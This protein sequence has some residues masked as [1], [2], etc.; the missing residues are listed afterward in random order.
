MNR[1]DEYPD[2]QDDDQPPVDLGVRRRA[3]PRGTKLLLSIGVVSGVGALLFFTWVG[4]QNAAHKNP[5]PTLAQVVEAPPKLK[6]DI[7]P[8]PPAP[9]EPPAGVAPPSHLD[10]SLWQL[11]AMEEPKIDLVKKRRLESTM[12]GAQQSSEP[13]TPASNQAPPPRVPVMSSAGP[14][15]QLQALTLQPATASQL[16][17]RNLLLTQG[18]MIDCVLLTRLVSTQP[19]MI[20]CQA[21]RDILSNN[22]KVVLVDA[23]SKF[24]GYQ[25]AG[26]AQGQARVFVVW[27]RLITPAGVTINLDS[28]GTGPLGEGGL[29]GAVDYHFGDR[30]SGAILVSLIG[31]L[32]RWASNRGNSGGDGV[33]FD[34]TTD[35]AANAVTTVL[36]NS[37]NIPPTLYKNQGERVG[38]FVARDLDFSSVYDLKPAAR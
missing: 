33:R 26:I 23:G 1:H 17:D 22:G 6:L 32:G 11:P 21:T 4:S 10:P 5:V 35:G 38:I 7:P 9:A 27:S 37:I 25:Q 15:S 31:D 19:G 30:F 28:P 16:S 8:P 12:T 29:S 34:N 24:I 2:H 3:A 20:S 14:M 36:E 13:T 18:T